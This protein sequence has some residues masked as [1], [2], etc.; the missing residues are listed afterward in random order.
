M[1]FASYYKISRLVCIVL[2]AVCKQYKNKV[3]AIF[4]LCLGKKS[5]VL[6]HQISNLGSDGEIYLCGI[7]LLSI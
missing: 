2:V 5:A 4:L 1:H 3:V 6:S 7:M